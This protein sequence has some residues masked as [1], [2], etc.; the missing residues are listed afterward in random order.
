MLL[1]SFASRGFLVSVSLKQALMICA[2]VWA[3][4]EEGLSTRSSG[5]PSP[6]LAYRAICQ[7]VSIVIFTDHVMQLLILQMHSYIL[8][9]MNIY[10]QLLQASN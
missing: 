5:S 2:V 4:G 10:V 1:I 7:G 6:F 9:F 8:T 3:L